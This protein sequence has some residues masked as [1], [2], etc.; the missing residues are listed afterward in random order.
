VLGLFLSLVFKLLAPR[1][2]SLSAQPL[3]CSLAPNIARV[4]K[5][6]F[7]THFLVL[8]HLLDLPHDGRHLAFLSR[9]IASFTI[10]P[11]LF[12]P[13]HLSLTKLLAR[14]LSFL[15]SLWFSAVVVGGAGRLGRAALVA[16]YRLRA[17]HV[18][19]IH[20]LLLNRKH[21]RH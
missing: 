3:S 19:C 7:L 12:V 14:C 17:H 21:R 2:T 4:A 13:L 15:A 1:P 20:G 9:Q 10:P 11:Q 6:T 8:L 16:H 18:Y 5:Q